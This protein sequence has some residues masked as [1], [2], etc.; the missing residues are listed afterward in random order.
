[1]LRTG[2]GDSVSKQLSDADYRRLYEFRARLVRFT[3]ASDQR[4]RD[5]GLTPTH[6]LLLLGIRASA[7]SRGPTIGDMAEFLILKHHSVVELV[8]RAEAAGLIKRSPDPDDGRVVRLGLTASGKQ[9]LERVAAVNYRELEQLELISDA[10]DAS[11][12]S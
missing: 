12:R 11:V 6:Y 8:D 3:R 2:R 1:M 5:A 10:L 9:R 7:S 4:V